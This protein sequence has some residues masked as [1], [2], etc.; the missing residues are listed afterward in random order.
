MTDDIAWSVD[1][2]KDLTAVGERNNQGCITPDP[3]V[4][5]RHPSFA[6]SQRRGNRAVGV[7]KGLRQKPTRLLFPDPLAG[8]IDG[9]HELQ[10]RVLIKA[11]CK[12]STGGRIRDPLCSQTIQERF[13]LATQLDILQPLTI[14]QGIVSQ[15]QNVITL[16]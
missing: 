11:S 10:N 12:I 15:V 6:L 14:E 13:L 1:Q 16:V 8:R 9:F 2:I 3:F 7:N 5:K 4:G